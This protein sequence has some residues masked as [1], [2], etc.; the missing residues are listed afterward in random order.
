MAYDK[1]HNEANGHGNTD[2]TDDNRSWNCGVEGDADA[3]E[4]VLAL[5]RRRRRICALM[6]LANGIP[7]IWPATSS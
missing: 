5:R 1:K 4:A 2:G 6:M 7:M 3:S